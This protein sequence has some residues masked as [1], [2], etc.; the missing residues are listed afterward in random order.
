[1]SVP[2]IE[3]QLTFLKNSSYASVSVDK[4]TLHAKYQKRSL[5]LVFQGN[6]NLVSQLSSAT[7]PQT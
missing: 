7:I 1:M 5:F 2:S 4:Y 3:H 6:Q